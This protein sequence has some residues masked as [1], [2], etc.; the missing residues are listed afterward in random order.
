MKRALSVPGVDA[1]AVTV[2]IG[3]D[4]NGA[5][6]ERRNGIGDIGTTASIGERRLAIAD[7]V[8]SGATIISTGTGI[9]G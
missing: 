4:G 5:T 8:G 3:A 1:I 7:I 2:L 9:A 6:V